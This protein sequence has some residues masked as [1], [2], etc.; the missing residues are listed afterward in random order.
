M[1]KAQYHWNMGEPPPELGDHSFAKHSIFDEYLAI[2]IDRV[3]RS[4]GQTMLN[5]T[6]V[7]GFCGGGVYRHGRN[8]VDGS[9]FHLLHAVEKAENALKAARTKGFT[10]RADFFFID[11]NPRHVAFLKH[12][13]VKRGYLSRIDTDIKLRCQSFEEAWPEIR[14]FVRAK[15]TAHRTLFF[16]DQFGWSDVRLATIREILTSLNNPEILLTFAVDALINFL[17]TKSSESS[18]LLAIELDREDVQQLTDMKSQAG[19]RYLIQNQLYLHIKAKT[20]APFYTP[21]FIHSPESHR[22][23]WLIHLATHHKARDEMAKL[24]WKLQNHFQHHGKA[25]FHALG[26]DPMRDIRQDMMPFMFD[27]DARKRSEA[28]VLEQLPRFVRAIDDDN[29]IAVKDLFAG[30]CN[31]SPVTSEILNSQLIFLRDEGELAIKSIDGVLKPRA[32]NIAWDDRIIIPRQR[33]FFG[34]FGVLS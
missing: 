1:S 30:N 8:E 9:P 13:M 12:E 6:I 32:R 11:S 15:G 26:F 16:L 24:H 34:R 7:D 18:A 4:P 20:E 31:E 23:Y 19:W 14:A 21:F 27:D 33:N 3:T 25:G 10:I 17:S 5:L 29:G 2:Y 22:S 28:A